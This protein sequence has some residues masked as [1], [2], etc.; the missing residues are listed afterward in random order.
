[1]SREAGVIPGP[2]QHTPP[3]PSAE[4]TSRRSSAPPSAL[5]PVALSPPAGER[6]LS[7]QVWRP[8]PTKGAWCGFA[9][10]A[11]AVVLIIALG[12]A[13]AG[14]QSTPTRLIAAALGTAACSIF[15]VAAIGTWWSASLT[16]VLGPAA[17]EIRSLGR[18]IRIHYRSLDRVTRMDRDVGSPP[19]LWPGIHVGRAPAEAGHTCTWR[20]TTTEPVHVIAATAGASSWIVTPAEPRAFRDALVRCAE[21]VPYAPQTAAPAR[22][23]LLDRLAMVDGWCRVA[24]AANIAVAAAGV[25]LDVRQH[26]AAQPDSLIAAGVLA[27]NA[28]LWL[29]VR[30]RASGVAR[31]LLAWSAVAYG[32]SILW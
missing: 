29:A 9:I 12:A 11:C 20:G 2:A 1:M 17:L 19:A 6:H 4:G 10:C 21:R 32:L 16:Y 30:H 24:F 15:V 18:R 8:A 27:A 25:A 13:Y 3:R 31:L 5:D 7:Q 22:R 28:M 14:T 26:G 23:S